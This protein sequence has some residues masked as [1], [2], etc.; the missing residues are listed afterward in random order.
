[1]RKLLA[2]VCAGILALGL[3]GCGGEEPKKPAAKKGAKK[4]DKKKTDDKKTDDKKTEKK[5]E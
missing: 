4:T 2:G 1:M 5:A 3:V